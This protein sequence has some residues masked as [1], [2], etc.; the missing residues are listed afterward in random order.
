MTRARALCATVA[1]VLLPILPGSAEPIAAASVTVIDG[2]T[3]RL[4]DGRP[5][6]R[7]VGFDAPE[8]GSRAQCPSEQALG[9]RATMRLRELIAGGGV[10]LQPVDCACRP[11]TAAT[12]KCN[13]GRSCAVL[14][15][16][17]KDA[18]AVLI[19][20]GLA[21]AYVL[22]P[23]QVP[24]PSIVVRRPEIKPETETAPNRPRCLPPAYLPFGWDSAEL[25]K[26]L[27]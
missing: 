1:L 3:I 4:D 25:P 27:G 19:S 12:L 20:E 24:A 7:L 17:S 22:Q 9:H 18:S 6:I 13:Y 10:D 21:R 14:V 5:N 16:R 8:T 26:L 11:G 23:R 2:D 15:I